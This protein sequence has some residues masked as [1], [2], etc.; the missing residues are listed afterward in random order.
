[1]DFAPETRTYGKFFEFIWTEL[2][3]LQNDPK[4]CGAL[5]CFAGLESKDWWMIKHALKYPNAP[6]LC[7]KDLQ[8]GNDTIDVAEFDPE[9]PYSIYISIDSLTKFQKSCYNPVAQKFILSSVLHELVHYLDF[10]KDKKFIDSDYDPRTHRVT[11]KAWTNGGVY[12]QGWMFE[13]AVYGDRPLPPP[14]WFNGAL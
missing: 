7:A 10:A 11:R 1:M 5:G 2:P 14:E 3:K 6:K 9:T 8:S 13:L 12:D 4:I